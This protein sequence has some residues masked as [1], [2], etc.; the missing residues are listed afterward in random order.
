[1]RFLL[2]NFFC[3]VSNCWNGVPRIRP[4]ACITYNTG[5]LQART[6]TECVLVAQ[7]HDGRIASSLCAKKNPS[8][9][10]PCHTHVGRFHTSCL[11]VHHST[12]HHLDR[13]TFS[14][15]TPYTDNHS[16]KNLFSL[17]LNNFVMSPCQQ[18]QSGR[19]T[20]L[21]NHSHTSTMRGPETCASTL[22][23]SKE[24]PRD[25]YK[26]RLPGEDRQKYGEDKV[27]RLIK[28]MYG[29]QDASHIWQRDYVTLICG[30]V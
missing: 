23:H 8:S 22:P 10:Q 30:E 4:A 1:M 27:G 28:S 26:I 5:C 20:T 7:G 17:Y 11:S 19:K 15:T 6:D 2:F 29:I 21:K 24:Q 16:R 3:R 14:M 12:Q 18:T 9:G 25:S 13:A